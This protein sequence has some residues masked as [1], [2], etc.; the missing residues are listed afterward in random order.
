[1]AMSGSLNDEILEIAKEALDSEKLDEVF[2]EK[3]QQ[4]FTDAF[5][6]ALQWGPVKDT[7]KKRLDEV[8]VPCIEQYDMGKYVVKL[9]EILEQLINESV[10]ADNR[11]LLINFKRIMS[12]PRNG[13]ISLDEVFKEYCNMV[14]VFVDTDDL[15]VDLDDDPSY[16]SVHVC[17]TIEEPDRPYTFYS[18]PDEKIVYFHPEDLEQDH[19]CYALRLR[20]YDWQKGYSMFFDAEPTLPGLTNLN[21][22][23]CYLLALSKAN[24][25]LTG[26]DQDLD[27]YVTPDAAPEATWS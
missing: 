15:E 7:I 5:E 22:F 6:R 26:C 4:S 2:R 24:V 3:I 14:A 23:E 18:S 9:E 21:S 8:L 10:V 17:A 12:T 11:N 19:L 16:K 1:M 20:K 13:Q 27:D 25:E